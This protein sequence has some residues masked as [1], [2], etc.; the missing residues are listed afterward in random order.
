[1]IYVALDFPRDCTTYKGPHNT[2]CL[3]TIWL[4]ADCLAEG[5]KYP[6]TFL[7]PSRANYLNKFNLR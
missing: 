3:N 7:P 1:M 6:G 2:A 4:T 5:D